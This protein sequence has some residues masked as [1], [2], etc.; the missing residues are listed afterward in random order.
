M[1]DFGLS[2]LLIIMVIAVLVIGPQD[3]PKVMATIGRVVRRLQYVRFAVSRQFE[4]FMQEHDLDDMRSHVNFEAKVFDEAEAD[5]IYD[6][7]VIESDTTSS[8]KEQS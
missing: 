4:D 8:E 7:Q 1:L 3:I 6:H 5:D 2:E